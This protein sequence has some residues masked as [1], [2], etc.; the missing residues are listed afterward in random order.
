[1]SEL[2]Q[3]FLFFLAHVDVLMTTLMYNCKIIMLPVIMIAVNVVDVDGFIIRE[4]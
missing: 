3:I 2:F 4:L 1:M